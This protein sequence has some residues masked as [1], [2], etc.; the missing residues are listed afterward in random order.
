M[1]QKPLF[2]KHKVLQNKNQEITMMTEYRLTSPCSVRNRS[3][4][5]KP[6]AIDKHSVKTTRIHNADLEMSDVTNPPT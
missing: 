2:A 3:A 4:T 6:P 1:K 5:L